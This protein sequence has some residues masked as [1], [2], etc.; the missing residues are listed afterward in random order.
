[1]A[2]SKAVYALRCSIDLIGK[3]YIRKYCPCKFKLTIFHQ[4]FRFN[5]SDGIKSGANSNFQKFNPK[6]CEI[7]FSTIKV[8]ANPLVH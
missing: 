8:L 2:S 7:V 1:M 4:E 6:A 3:D 5:M